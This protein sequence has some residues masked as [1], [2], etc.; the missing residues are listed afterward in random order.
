MIRLIQRHL[1]IPRGDTG[2]F[3]LPIK[4]PI[5]SGDIAVFIIFNPLT[6]TVIFNKIISLEADAT[7]LNVEFSYNDTI[8]LTPGRYKWDVKIYHEPVYDEDDILIGATQV[9]SYYAAYSLPSC[10]IRE[11]GSI[12]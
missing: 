4:E 6:Q 12:L 1:I 11:G 10:D 2:V 9:N 7:L 5:A 3:S 8:D